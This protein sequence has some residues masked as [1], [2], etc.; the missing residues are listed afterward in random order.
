MAV[1][2][3]DEVEA[4]ARAG[5]VTRR[6]FLSQVGAAG[7]LRL[8]RRWWLARG[9]PLSRWRGRQMARRRWRIR[10]PSR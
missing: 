2:D 5:K 1:K 3:E 6:S 4:P 9:R 8:R 7:L 10:W